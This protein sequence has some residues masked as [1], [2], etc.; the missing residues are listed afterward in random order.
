MQDG[1]HFWVSIHD[2]VT[3]R[4]GGG[5]AQLVESFDNLN[6]RRVKLLELALKPEEKME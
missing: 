2:P 5:F 4:L 6:A 1:K 3:W